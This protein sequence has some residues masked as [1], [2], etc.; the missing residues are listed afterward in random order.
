MDDVESHN[1]NIIIVAFKNDKPTMKL[2]RTIFQPEFL[3][4]ALE[5]IHKLAP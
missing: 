4:S 3:A 5:G 1:N 2:K